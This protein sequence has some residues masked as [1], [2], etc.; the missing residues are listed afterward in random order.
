MPNMLAK[1]LSASVAANTTN[2]SLF[3]STRF[4]YA[5]RPGFI[6]IYVNGSAAGLTARLLIGSEEVVESSQ[7]NTQNRFPVVPDDLLF[8]GIAVQ[9]GQRIT[10]EVSNTTGGALTVFARMELEAAMNYAG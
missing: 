3:G 2:P 7:V 4:E 8:G 9:A 6:N 10:L 1:Q 5:P